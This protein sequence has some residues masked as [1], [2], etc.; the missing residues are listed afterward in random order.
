LAVLSAPLSL[1]NGPTCDKEQR[2]SLRCEGFTVLDQVQEWLA[3]PWLEP[4]PLSVLSDLEG[5]Q[6]KL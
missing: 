4:D 5:L 2:L 3:V 6:P 1:F